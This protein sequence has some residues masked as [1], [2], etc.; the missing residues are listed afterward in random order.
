MFESL[1]DSKRLLDR[2]HYFNMI[3]A[4]KI[5]AMLQRSW[6]RNHLLTGL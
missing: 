1:G 4:K 3:D 2:F 6:K 5:S